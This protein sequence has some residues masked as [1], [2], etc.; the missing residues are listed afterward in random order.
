MSGSGKTF[1]ANQLLAK[2]FHFAHKSDWLQD[3]RRVSD[4]GRGSGRA[5]GVGEAVAG[6]EPGGGVGEATL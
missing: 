6:G 2:M 5:R 4:R 3:L 1:T